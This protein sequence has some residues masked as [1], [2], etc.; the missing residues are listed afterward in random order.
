MSTASDDLAKDALNAQEETD[1]VANADKIAETLNALQG[2]IER[3]ARELQA[4]NKKLKEKRE[5]VKNTFDNN[6]D[7][8]AVEEKAKAITTELKEQKSK[9]ANDPTLVNLK[10]E[11][12]ELAQEKREIEETLSSHLVNYHQLTGSTSFDTSDGDQWE[13][14]ISARVKSH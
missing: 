7:L 10:L 2:V 3:S 8:A 5:L 9:V 4:L 1:E 13:F 14:K 11:L 12:A 6:Q